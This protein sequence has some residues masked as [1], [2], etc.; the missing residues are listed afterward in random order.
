MPNSS[1]MNLSL[2][3]SA[4]TYF[5]HQ[6]LEQN[7]LLID[8]HNHSPGQGVQISSNGIT[9]GGIQGSNIAAGTI[10]SNLIGAGQVQST[11]I[12]AG[13]VG[14]SQ[15][16]AGAVTAGS[17]ASNTFAAYPGVWWPLILA[18]GITPANGY[19]TPSVRVEASSAVR[20]KGGIYN[21]T[22][23]TITGTLATIP[24]EPGLH[25]GYAIPLGVTIFAPATAGQIL[26]NTN[27]A[28]TL[29]GGLPGTSGANL[30]ILDGQSYT[31]N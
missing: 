16:A 10:T 30:L 17:V 11:N 1:Y 26:I 9:A 25:P 8:S 6:Q 23:G 15:I 13:A 12:G 7:F 27:G 2:W 28:I 14:T 24:L 20:F 4:G 3:A 18:S 22:E 29:T 31:I 21:G 5:N 19:V